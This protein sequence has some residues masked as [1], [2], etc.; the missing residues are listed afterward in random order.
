MNTSHNTRHGT[1]YSYPLHRLTRFEQGPLY[2]CIKL[3]N[4]LPIHIKQIKTFTAFKREVYNLLCELEP[5]TLT[6]YYTM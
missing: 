4:Y 5:Y 3:Y 2:S 1:S 6:D